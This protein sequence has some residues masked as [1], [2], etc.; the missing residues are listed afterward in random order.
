MKTF[1]GVTP[2]P[3]KALVPIMRILLKP[4]VIESLALCNLITTVVDT[5]GLC[6]C[7]LI[8]ARLL[9]SNGWHSGFVVRPS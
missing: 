2:V 9:V 5:S 8:K 3:P 6:S 4:M 7:N 1:C